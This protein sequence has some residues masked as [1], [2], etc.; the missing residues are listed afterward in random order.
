MSESA[1]LTF[2]DLQEQNREWANRNFDPNT[3][4]WQPLLGAVEELGELAHAHLKQAQSIRTNEDHEANGRDAVADVIIYLCDYSSRRGWD[5]Q[6]IVETAWNEVKQRDWKKN[7]ST[8]GLD[9]IPVA[10]LFYVT[11]ETDHRIEVGQNGELYPAS[12]LD[13]CESAINYY[14]EAEYPG[15]PYHVVNAE[16]GKLYATYTLD[17]YGELVVTKAEEA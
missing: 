12:T 3:P 1:A 6:E 15:W 2:R 5:L 10:P 8:A 9:V 14:A 13:H 16:T 7:P 17:E 11:D 4:A